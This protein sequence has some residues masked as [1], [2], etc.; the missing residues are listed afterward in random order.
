MFENSYYEIMLSGANPD[1][2]AM[3]AAL[4]KDW[5]DLMADAQ[6]RD[7][8]GE[9]FCAPTAFNRHMRVGGYPAAANTYSSTLVTAFLASG[10]TTILQKRLAALTAYTRDFGTDRYKPL[11][12]GQLKKVT[13]G[14]TTLTNATNFEAG[15]SVVTNVPVTVAQYTQSF[16]VSNSDLNSGLRMEDIA[17]VNA[18]LFGN[19]LTQ[20]ATAPITEANF[21]NYAGGSYV[22]TPAAFGWGDMAQI[23]GAIKH[24]NFKHAIL[25]GEFMANLNNTPGSFQNSGING[26]EANAFGWDG[27]HLNTEWTGAGA[28]C[29]GFACDPQAIG[30]CSGLP[31]SLA[32]QGAQNIT[33]TTFA[34]PGI[35]L[36][37]AVYS[38]FSLSSRTLWASYD[39]MLGAAA[40]DTTA[41]VFIKAS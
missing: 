29:R 12:T 22:Q 37:I 5:G 31:V 16:Q 39:V 33:E 7:A 28:G 13:A 34:L 6:A 27:I 26:S 17:K 36:T 35:G 20:I 14:S 30:V 21:A 10:A 19:K 25:D 2:Q 3:N 11:A 23:W 41:G 15:D 24:A 1:M 18:N 8:R 9:M 40:L 4:R 38:W 32:A